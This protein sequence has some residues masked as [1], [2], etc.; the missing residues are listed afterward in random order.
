MTRKKTAKMIL[1]IIVGLQSEMSRREKQV[2][3]E[4]KIEEKKT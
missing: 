3:E 1:T 4:G 2:K